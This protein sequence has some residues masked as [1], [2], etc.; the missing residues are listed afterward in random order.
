[1]TGDRRHPWTISLLTGKNHPHGMTTRVFRSSSSKATETGRAAVDEDALA[2]DGAVAAVV[3]NPGHQA[4]G[5]CYFDDGTCAPEGIALPEDLQNV[6]APGSPEYGYWLHKWE[7]H[8]TR[9]L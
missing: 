3:I 1:M 5:V 6:P 2:G 4:V 8:V 9:L 7:Q